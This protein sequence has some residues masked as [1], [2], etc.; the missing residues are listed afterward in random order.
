MEEADLTVYKNSRNMVIFQKD[1]A[2]CL[3]TLYCKAVLP[4]TMLIDLTIFFKGVT[5]FNPYTHTKKKQP[6]DLNC[7]NHVKFIQKQQP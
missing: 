2:R 5:E 3:Q 6:D 1:N 7:D 4:L